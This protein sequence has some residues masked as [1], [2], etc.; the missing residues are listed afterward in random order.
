MG[1]ITPIATAIT[2]GYRRVI[3]PRGCDNLGKREVIAEVIAANTS[4]Y[5]RVIAGLSQGYRTFLALLGGA[6]R[7]P[8]GGPRTQ[9][10]VRGGF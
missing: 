1:A 7:G 5:R 9:K 4:G 3:A 10:V 6:G 8:G 2:S